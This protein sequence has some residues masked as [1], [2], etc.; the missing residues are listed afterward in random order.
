[1]QLFHLIFTSNATVKISDELLRDIQ[2]KAV[3]RNQKRGITGVLL[4]SNHRFLQILE[5]TAADIAETFERI[6]LDA[7]HL[8]VSCVYFGITEQR[9]FPEASMG[10][11]KSNDVDTHPTVKELF[12]ALTAPNQQ[13]KDRFL[14]IA[15]SFKAF[16][17]QVTPE[18]VFAIEHSTH[19]MA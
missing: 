14:Q 3:Y 2:E 9:M 16:Q 4:C 1:M 6:S 17:D 12:D 7:R 8:D 18:A 15:R 10:V 13:E 5:G 19:G 11:V